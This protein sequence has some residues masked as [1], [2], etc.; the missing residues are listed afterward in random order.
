MYKILDFAKLRRTSHVIW[1]IDGTITDRGGSVNTEVSAKIINLALKGVYHTFIT[2]RDSAWVIKHVI[3]PMKTFYNFARVRDSLS[4]FA[5]SGCVTIT[6]H[7]D[8]GVTDEVLPA[9]ARHPLSANEEGGIRGRLRT[10]VY[11]PGELKSYDRGAPVRPPAGVIH[12]AEGNG[13]LIDRSQPGPK[14]NEYVWSTSK[15][16]FCTL[17]KIRNEDGEVRSFDQGPSVEIVRREI[18]EAGLKA[19]ADVQLAA[20]AI[21]IVPIIAD[22]QRVGK[23]WAAGQA[24]QAVQKEKL[25]GGVVLATVMDRT[26]A[27]GDSAADLEFT[28][29]TFDAQR[30]GSPE[31]GSVRMIFVGREENLPQPHDERY[32]LRRNIIIQATGLGDLEFDWT[33]DLIRLEAA[34]GAR[35]VSSVL[36]FLSQWD[37]FGPFE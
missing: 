14:C 11:D 37:Y 12:D 5:E 16:V 15:K 35:V 1:D 27:V 8:G 2:G 30:S 19:L 21:D 34:T 26:I 18:E 3:E 25:G 4:F 17:E 22:A 28:Q 23:S 36:D 20:T 32:K 10:L 33:K 24:L 9:L 31:E 13:W 29:P 6:V 7:D